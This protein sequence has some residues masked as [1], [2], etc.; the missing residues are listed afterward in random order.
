MVW[1][2]LGWLLVASCLGNLFGT[3]NILVAVIAGILAFLCFRKG[4]SKTKPSD[5]Q[6]TGYPKAEVPKRTAPVVQ[7]SLQPSVQGKATTTVTTASRQAVADAF[8]RRTSATEK[9]P[10]EQKFAEILAEC[11]PGYTV[12]RNV[13]FPS[14]TSEWWVCSCGAENIGSFCAECG[15]TK[16]VSTEWTCQCGCHNTSKFCSDCGKA[17]PAPVQYE[18]IDFLLMRDGMPKL[19]ILLV[20]RRRWNTKLIRNTIEAC[21]Q[22]GIP[23][24]RYFEEYDNDSSYV[25]DRI[26]RDLR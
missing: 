9:P 24:Q 8:V 14:M 4:N 23:W 20:T 12:K 5:T 11:F 10:V 1:K 26:G 3:G 17:K 13:D 2:I 22:A 18:P 7:N 19:A 6:Q 15:N 25:T 21:E 16:P